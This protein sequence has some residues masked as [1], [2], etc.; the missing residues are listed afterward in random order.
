MRLT[1]GSK[2]EHNDYSGFEYQPSGRLAWT[3][4]ERHTVW[5]AISRAVRSPSRIDQEF[6][7][8][9]VVAGGSNFVSEEL[10]AYELGYRVQPFQKL[11]FSLAA[12]YNDYKNIRSLRTN[13]PPV[14]A[15]DLKG[16]SYGTE[17]SGAYQLTQWWRLRAGYTYFH[18]RLSLKAGGSDANNGIAEGNDPE[19]QLSLRSSMDLPGHLEFDG[20][21]RYVDTLPAPHVPGYAELDLRLAWK[22]IQT[23]QVAVVGQNLLHS[24][25]PEFG[26][27]AMR[28]EIE[29]SVYGKVTW[30]F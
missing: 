27:P 15:N 18:K 10:L 23:V 29:R 16:Y 5:G 1:L 9:G 4:A 12:F 8:P 13:P 3:P 24:S 7:L 19:H 30:S 28:Q 14:I 11:S 17:L 22:P 25:H 6:F 20:G 21:V 26:A 2:F